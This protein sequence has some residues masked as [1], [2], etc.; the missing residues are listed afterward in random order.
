[1]E[2]GGY[3]TPFLVVWGWGTLKGREPWCH[4]FVFVM[5]IAVVFSISATDLYSA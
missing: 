3:S 4:V 1:M 2:K 5:V